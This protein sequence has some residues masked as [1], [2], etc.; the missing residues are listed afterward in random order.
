[1]FYNLIMKF[2]ECPE[3][4]VINATVSPSGLVAEGTVVTITCKKPRR[5]VLMG[6]KYVT[7]QSTG[8]SDTP[9]C[10]KCGKFR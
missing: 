10:R 8:W 1:M 7:C 2:L 3:L 9:E 4:K 5:Y 6:E